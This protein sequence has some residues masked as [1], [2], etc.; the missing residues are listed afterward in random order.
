ME[1]EQKVPYWEKL[2]RIERRNL[3]IA[4][5]YY[6]NGLRVDVISRDYGVARGRIYQILNL[7]KEK[8]VEE[9]GNETD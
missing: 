5:D 7:Y 1:T 2:K 3:K 6:D 9:N 8:K 4:Q